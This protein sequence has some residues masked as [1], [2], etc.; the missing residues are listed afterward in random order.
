MKAIVRSSSSRSARYLPRE[1]LAEDAIRDRSRRTLFG[2]WGLMLAERAAYASRLLG[3]E[4][5]PAYWAAGELARAA[6]PTRGP[7]GIP[8]ACAAR[9]PAGAPAGGPPSR[10]RSAVVKQRIGH[11][12]VGVDRIGRP[13]AACGQAVGDGQERDIDLDGGGRAEIS[14]DGAAPRAAGARAPG[15]RLGDG[16]ARVLRRGA[17]SR[18]LEAQAPEQ[19]ARESG[20]LYVVPDERHP[21]ILWPTARVSGLAESCKSAPQRSASPRVRSSASGSASS[22]ATPSP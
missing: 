17:R 7:A 18:S 22:A 11:R 6:P 16:C 14:V 5:S 2:Q 21:A 13:I 19:H 9:R 8:S 4:T 10:Q 3:V 20:T 1:D 15:N 12:D